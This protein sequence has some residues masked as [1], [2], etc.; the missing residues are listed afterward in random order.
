MPQIYTYS[1]ELTH[2]GRLGMKWGQHIFGKERAS[3]TRKKRRSLREIRRDRKESKI[4]RARKNLEERE[5]NRRK[6]ILSDP[7]LLDKHKA[8]FTSE[9]INKAIDRFRVEKN[10]TAIANETHSERIKVANRGKDYVKLVVDYTAT[11]INAYNNVARIYNAFSDP[12]Q[13]KLPLIQ[14]KPQQAQQNQ[15]SQQNQTQQ[16]Q[17]KKK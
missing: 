9:E 16:D 10:L 7:K 15:N 2:Y 5:V 14:D 4:E 3:S 13:K 6:T 8:E 1:D 17:Q 11:S 12:N